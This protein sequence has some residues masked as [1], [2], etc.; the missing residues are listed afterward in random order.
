MAQIMVSKRVILVST[1]SRAFHLPAWRR[2]IA[3]A[4]SALAILMERYGEMLVRS[5]CVEGDFGCAGWIDW[6]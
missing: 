3:G 4:L 1:R 5:G 2:F 6:E